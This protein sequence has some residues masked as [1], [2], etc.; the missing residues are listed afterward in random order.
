MLTCLPT[1][2]RGNRMEVLVHDGIGVWLVA[3]R[4]NQGKF[5]WPRDGAV[6]MTLTRVQLDA[7]VLCLPSQRQEALKAAS[8]SDDV[9]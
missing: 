2:R 4:L 8:H 1:N 3:R 6:P 5:L 9:A 7:L